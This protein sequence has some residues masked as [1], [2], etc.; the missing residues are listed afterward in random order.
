MELNELSDAVINGDQNRAQELTQQAIDEGMA[1]QKVIND[2][3]CAGM[4]VVGEKFRCSEYYVP[5]VL[6][7]ARAM[8]TS[9]EM[10]KPLLQD[11]EIE[12]LGKVVIGTAKGDLHDIGKNLVAMMLEGSGFEV[13]DIGADAPPEK[14]VEEAREHSAQL[15][16]ISALMTTTMTAMKETVEALSAAGMMDQVKVMIGGAP[17]TQAFAD[18]IGAQG[19]GENA[20]EAV[21]VA[22]QLIGA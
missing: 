15:V 11:G 9:M 7:A 1:L 17:V 4:E 2:G 22:K 5:Q 3:L 6:L 12:Y 18:E 8:K 14:Y 19:F 10:L 16:L 13:F 20:S 21:K